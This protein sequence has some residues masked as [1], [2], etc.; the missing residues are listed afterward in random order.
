MPSGKL[1]ISRVFVWVMLVLPSISF[2]SQV[3]TEN[4]QENIISLIDEGWLEDG[5]D[6]LLKLVDQ[7]PKNAF[8]RFQLAK[9]A[10]QLG[11]YEMADNQ[12]RKCIDLVDDNSEYQVLRGH[13]LGAIARRGSK[14]KALSRAKNC[15]KAYEKAIKLDPDN[16]EARESLMMFHIFAPGF[17][18][19]KNE[20]ARKLAVAIDKIDHLHGI[21]AAAQ[22]LHNLDD[23]SSGAH[24]MYQ[25]AL[26]EFENDS[27]PFFEYG[28]YLN[29]Q[30]E[31]EEA[32][33]IF[34]MGVQRDEHPDEA[35]LKRGNLLRMQDHPE[36]ALEI[37]GRVLTLDPSN[38]EA[39]IFMSKIYLDSEKFTQA[40][41]I[42]DGVFQEDPDSSW[43][44]YQQGVLFFKQGKDLPEAESDIRRYLN[45][46]LN[47]AWDSRSTAL[48][49]LAKVLEK[50]GQ[51][52]KALKVV[53]E[54]SELAPFSDFLKD[55]VKKMEF[56]GS[57][58]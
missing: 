42:L 7:H 34:E 17:V 19:G 9:A 33:R 56:M 31:N 53:K 44:F 22:I 52:T 1:K 12:S 20:E 30:N 6:Q 18:G 54:A 47:A 49:H 24:K 43:A 39:K 15:L 26:E 41:K 46:R 3:L 25:T 38:L 14:V 10:L 37:Y 21:F 32:S 36:E 28:G 5:R 45:S 51:Y 23:D 58:D 50:R 29:Q 48:Y 8:L 13:A 40:Q 55:E 4:Q 57:D 11:E 2:A 16:I 35:L 27:E